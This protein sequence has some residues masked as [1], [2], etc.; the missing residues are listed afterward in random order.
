MCLS[1]SEYLSYRGKK[2]SILCS[3]RH[4][5][6]VLYMVPQISIELRTN[7]PQIVKLD[8]FQSRIPTM[9]SD[10]FPPNLCLRVFWFPAKTKREKHNQSRQ[11]SQ[12][13]GWCVFVIYTIVYSSIYERSLSS[14]FNNYWHK[15]IQTK[16]R[17]EIFRDSSD[18][19]GFR[20]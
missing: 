20:N 14:L 7:T 5:E 10:N 2:R 18:A 13:L 12:L 3:S 4:N 8:Q 17:I 19:H 11:K 6:I 1:W 9:E 16:I 15:N